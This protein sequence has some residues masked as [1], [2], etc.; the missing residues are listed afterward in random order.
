MRIYAHFP[1]YGIKLIRWKIVTHGGID[2]KTRVV[3]YLRAS[4]NNRAETVAKAFKSATEIYGW[5]SRVR[6][7]WGGENMQV[8]ALMEEA[9][10]AGRGSFFAGA[11]THNQRIESMGVSVPYPSF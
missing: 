5:P 6:A 3:V 2:G 10:G 1:H 4:N 8:K 9:R 7:D 11:S